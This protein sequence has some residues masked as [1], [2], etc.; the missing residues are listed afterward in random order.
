MMSGRVV[1]GPQGWMVPRMEVAQ[2]EVVGEGTEST[3]TWGVLFPCTTKPKDGRP[4]RC[5]C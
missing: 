2:Y 5:A 4:G 3:C 1:A